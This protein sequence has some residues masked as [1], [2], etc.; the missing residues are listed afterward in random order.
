[1]RVIGFITA[2]GGSKGVPRKNLQNLD[3]HPLIAYMIR[4]ALDAKTLDRLVF[5]T[6]DE[7]IAEVARS[8][9]IEVPFLRPRKFAEDHVT[10]IDVAQHMVQAMDESGDRGDVFVHMFP[11]SPFVPA[12]KI[13]AIVRMV[14]EKGCDSGLAVRK[15]EHEHPARML[16]LDDAGIATPMFARFAKMQNVN[17]QDLNK[18]YCRAGAVYARQRALLE[19]V[20]NSTFALGSKLG[21]VV[22]SDFESINIDRQIDFA[23]S[24]FALDKGYAPSL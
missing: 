5:S 1:M 23:M 21:A 2:R 11:T 13:D 24:E 9:G 22:L 12:D 17:R 7:E 14:T 16:S 18:I 4:A 20:D 10:G 15:V 8:Y 19:T 6:E 3:G